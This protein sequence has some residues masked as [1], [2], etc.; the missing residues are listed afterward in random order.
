[1][2]EVRIVEK[3]ICKPSGRETALFQYE[4]NVNVS[5]VRACL[6]VCNGTLDAARKI[7]N[8]IWMSSITGENTCLYINGV[9]ECVGN[10]IAS[11]AFRMKAM[12]MF[13]NKEAYALSSTSSTAFFVLFVFV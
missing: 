6:S 7:F 1:M 4:L 3:G 8:A 13:K 12:I 10:H 5:C 2:Y 9:L 11:L